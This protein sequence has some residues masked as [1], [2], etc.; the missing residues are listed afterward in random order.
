METTYHQLRAIAMDVDQQRKSSPAF[1]AFNKEKIRR[2]FDQNQFRLS[3]MNE[4]ILKIAKKHCEL[5]VDGNPMTH[6]VK[7]KGKPTSVEYKFK[8]AA[9]EKAYN[10]EYDHF[11]STSFRIHI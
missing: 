1:A 6:E 11:M 8:D 5:D 10:E 2:F 4:G 7:K 3:A 9:A